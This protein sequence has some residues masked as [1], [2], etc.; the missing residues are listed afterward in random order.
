MARVVCMHVTVPADGRN[1]F[2]KTSLH[3][4]TAKDAM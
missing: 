3:L 4:I 1:K 2:V